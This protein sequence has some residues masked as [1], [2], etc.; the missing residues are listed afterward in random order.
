MP[1]KP[2]GTGI[3]SLAKSLSFVLIL[4]R[5]FEDGNELYHGSFADFPEVTTQGRSIEEAMENAQNNLETFFGIHHPTGEIIPE[6]IDDVYK[7]EEYQGLLSDQGTII[8]LIRCNPYLALV[9]KCGSVKKTLTI[10]LWLN[11]IAEN[12]GEKYSELLQNALIEDLKK[13]SLTEDEEKLLKA[14]I[15]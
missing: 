11:E 8:T 6:R 10:P 1:R 13:R 15:N 9:R 4:K 12:H 2:A 7:K 5:D 3:R 14:G